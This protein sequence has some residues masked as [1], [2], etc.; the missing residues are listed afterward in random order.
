[1]SL[2]PGGVE[3]SRSRVAIKREE[4]GFA[5]LAT[6]S[7]EEGAQEDVPLYSKES[8]NLKNSL[9]AGSDGRSCSVLGVVTVSFGDGTTEARRLCPGEVF[10]ERHIC[11]RR[12]SIW[13]RPLRSF[14]LSLEEIL[15]KARESRVSIST[16]C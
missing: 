15:S 5:T 13:R 11:A 6:G 2:V 10:W 1:M 12:P 8:C 9:K 7:A 14:E 4:T 16:V 3:S